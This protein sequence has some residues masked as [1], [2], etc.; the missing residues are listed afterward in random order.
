MFVVRRL[1]ELAR[2]EGV[3]LY[4]CFVDL[5]KSYDFVDRSLFL[6]V[7]ARFGVPPV[8]VDIVLQ[9][10]DS[11]RACVRLDGGRVS[12]WFEVGQGLRQ[13][14]GLAPILFNIF[15]AVLTTAEEGLRAD[16]QVEADLVSIR[17]TP[18]AVR[19]GDETPRTSTIWSMLYVDDAEIVSRSPASLAKI[20]TAVVDGC[21]GY[22]VT[23]EERKTET[24]IMRPPHHAQEDLEKVAAGLRYAQTEQ[25]VH[26]GGTITAEADMTAEIRRRT[27]AAWSAFLRYANASTTD[28][29]HRLLL[30]CV[31]FRKSQRSDHPLS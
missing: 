3:P 17:S 28:Q 25:F 31:G 19:D 14:C 9:F 18:L 15:T 5:K 20:M 26:L 2:K 27:G 4:T 23:V 24:K 7:L 12:E 16:S 6:V 21:G 8:M 1:Q 11:M 10:H 13:G 30:R 29:H 22:G